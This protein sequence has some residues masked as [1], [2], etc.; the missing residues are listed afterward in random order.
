MVELLSAFPLAE[1]MDKAPPIE[2]Y[3]MTGL[4]FGAVLFLLCLYKRWFLLL[5]IF[6]VFWH[7]NGFD[8]PEDPF[9]GAIRRE[10]PAYADSRIFSGLPIVL[11][12][13]LGAVLSGRKRG[14]RLG[15]SDQSR[16]G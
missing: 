12:S 7:F 15:D 3:W 13:L 2:H 16:T 11:G 1:V 8:E 14:G 9:R 4:I 10:D 5:S 6:V